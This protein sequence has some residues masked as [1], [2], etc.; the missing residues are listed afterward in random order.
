MHATANAATS[1]SRSKRP[2]SEP[3]SRHT[4]CGTLPPVTTSIAWLTDPHLDMVSAAT[5]EALLRSI[6]DQPA[7]ALVL[8]GDIAEADSLLPTLEKFEQELPF[9]T[10]FVL[11]N[12]DYYGS[13][14]AK[15]R[16][17]VSTWSAKTRQ[18]TWLPSAGII[19]LSASTALVGHGG[20]GDGGYGDFAASPIVLNDYRRIHELTGKSKEHLLKVLQ[21]LGNEA[22]VYLGEQVEHAWRSHEHVIVATHVPPFVEACWHEGEATLNEWTP[23][24]SCEGVGRRLSSLARNYPTRSMTVLCG[25]THSAGE[26]Q[27]LP[28]LAVLT[29][30]AKYGAPA[31]QPLVTFV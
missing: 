15:T 1:V 29:G 20:W 22:G 8:T 23:H 9:P 19:S 11:G 18:T 2:N 7:K 31:M 30:S 28:N 5:T 12:H 14:V 17:E 10:Y 3:Y 21:A 13:S 4:K 26:S 25:H 24:F 6:A 27:I 16:T